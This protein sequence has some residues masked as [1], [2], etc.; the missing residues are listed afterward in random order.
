MPSRNG[1]IPVFRMNRAFPPATVL[2]A[3]LLLAGCGSKR[4][5]KVSV[6][7]AP[8]SQTA[9]K[10]AENPAPAAPRQDTTV[11]TLEQPK[12]PKS[13]P[14]PPLKSIYTETGTASW[15]GPY[16]NNRPT[17][18]GELYDMNGLSAAHRTLPFNSIVRVTALGNG[19][20]V[21]V[22]ITD[23]GPFIAD[24]I[25]DLSYAAAKQLEMHRQGTARVKVEVLSSPAEIAA[26]GRWAVQIGAF[27]DADAAAKVKD[28]LERRYH[29]A[30]VLKYAG[31]TNHWWVRVRVLDD[32]R[33]RA[34]E[35]ARD[36]QTPQGG[37]FLVRLD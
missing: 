24:R 35:L 18:N 2:A 19:R 5:A 14:S 37:I 26:G 17:S 32:D 31:P 3:A 30:K 9:P 12:L 15:Y 1:L 8:S 16:F 29:T 10:A 6:P 33:H 23:R 27:Q 11:A 22:R 25:I 21:V 36:N 34:E 4:G 7:P 13:A 20:S 28:N